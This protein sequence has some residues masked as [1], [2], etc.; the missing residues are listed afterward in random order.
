MMSRHV[1][2]QSWRTKMISGGN[3]QLTID[4][5]R[6]AFRTM[7][8]RLQV[9]AEEI[10]DWLV[11]DAKLIHVEILLAHSEKIEDPDKLVD[12]CLAALGKM[13]CSIDG[14]RFSLRGP[15]I[16]LALEGLQNDDGADLKSVMYA[17]LHD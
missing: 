13:K 11:R 4:E 14:A 1:A 2:E 16:D 17:A 7:M 12:Y 15:L 8:R 3:D 5:I 9:T 6:R 10:P